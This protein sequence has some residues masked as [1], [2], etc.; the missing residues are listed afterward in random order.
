LWKKLVYAMTGNGLFLEQSHN[1]NTT[2][3]E[4]MTDEKAADVVRIQVQYCGG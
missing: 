2:Y 3:Q 1:T 4:G